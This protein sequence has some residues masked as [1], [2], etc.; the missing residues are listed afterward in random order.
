MPPV[1]NTWRP[2][3]PEPSPVEV[4]LIAQSRRQAPVTAA[5]AA[6]GRASETVVATGSDPPRQSTEVDR[7]TPALERLSIQDSSATGVTSNGPRE[8]EAMGDGMDEG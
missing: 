7:M 8:G 6:T 4:L 1:V 3:S 5:T 2:E